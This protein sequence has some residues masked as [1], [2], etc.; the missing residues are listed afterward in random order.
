VKNGKPYGFIFNIPVGVEGEKRSVE[1]QF[2]ILAKV[3]DFFRRS[4]ISYQLLQ[5]S[6]PTR[7]RGA[8][9]NLFT[10]HNLIFYFRSLPV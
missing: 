1:F 8:A 2:L 4:R 3:S 7:D 6:F 9:R 10:M 5:E